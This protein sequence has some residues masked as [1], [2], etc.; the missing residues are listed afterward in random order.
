[1]KTTFDWSFYSDNTTEE[2]RPA[3]VPERTFYVTRYGSH[4]FGTNIETS[5]EDFRG[6]CIAPEE[7]YHG[8]MNSSS[9]TFEDVTVNKPVDLVVF[10]IRKFMSMAAECNPNALELLYTDPSDHLLV[11]PA[12]EILLDNRDKFLTK[13]ARERFAGYARSQV[14][15][16]KL[17]YEWLH[18]KAPDHPPTRAEFGLSEP[19]L[20]S[21]E[22]MDAA[23]AT[24]RKKL[25]DWNLK[26]LEKL[27]PALRLALQEKMGEML[28]EAQVSVDELW[29]G[30][31]RTLG[32]SENF[33]DLIG[34]E[35][36][37]RGAVDRWKNYQKWLRERNLDRALLEFKYGYD[38]KHGMHLVRLLRM[39]REILTLG[40]VIVRRPDAEELK[41]IRRG[42]WTYPQM[43]A[44][45]ERENAALAELARDSTL[46]DDPDYET[47]NAICIRIV[48]EAFRKSRVSV[49]SK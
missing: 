30:A 10:E 16:M 31:S 39:A 36:R 22:Q 18:G 25:D 32:Y 47:L 21:R 27:S 6:I 48:E 26:G 24:V 23:L 20:M 37:F 1:M 44:F 5:D 43:L 2:A 28:A 8:F 45:A 4:A 17:H 14:H 3:W 19:P 7:H 33:I 42:A 46:P 13:A 49:V 11:S 9:N 15:R 29:V 12:A 34:K 40:K 41:A 35:K 38:V